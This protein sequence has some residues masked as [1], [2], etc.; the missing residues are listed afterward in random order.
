MS[1]FY[2]A[3]ARHRWHTCARYGM[4]AG[5]Q[6]GTCWQLADGAVYFCPPET[7]AEVEARFGQAAEPF[8]VPLVNCRTCAHL[9]RPG[10]SAGYCA[11]RTDLPRAHGADSTHPLRQLPAD[12]GAG[13]VF[14]EPR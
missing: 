1:P 9:A 3:R 13:C 11:V 12:G 14:W 7:R 8:T 2:P 4:T 6:T 5:L 10:L